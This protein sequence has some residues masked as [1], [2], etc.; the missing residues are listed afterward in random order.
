MPERLEI[1]LDEIAVADLNQL[2]ADFRHA[3]ALALT[4]FLNRRARRVARP[5]FVERNEAS[6]EEVSG[7]Q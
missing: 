1:V 7:L 3:D 2:I 5:Q 6:A 4:A